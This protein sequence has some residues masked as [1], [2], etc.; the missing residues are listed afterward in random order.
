MLCSRLVAGL[1]AEEAYGCMELVGKNHCVSGSELYGFLKGIAK[2]IFT[3]I[4]VI[5]ISF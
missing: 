4:A 5:C 3:E 2:G 1:E